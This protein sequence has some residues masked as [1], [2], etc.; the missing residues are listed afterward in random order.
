[1]NSPDLRTIAVDLTPIL[2]GGENGG[3]KV[4]V[5][6]LLRGLFV[7]APQTQFILLTQASS[8]EELAV[9]DAPNVQ[10]QMVVGAAV[11]NSLRPGL[12]GMASR[13]LPYLPGSLRNIFYRG[14]YK[15]HT[16]LKRGGSRKLMRDKGVDLLFC[17]FTG[18]TYAE[19]GI[20]TICTIYDL[21]YK[22]YPQFF[23]PADY[24]IRE[25]TF[26]DA[27]HKATALTAI[28]DYSR[29]SA[30]ANSN[31]DPDRISTIHL[32]MAQRVSSGHVQDDGVLQRLGLSRQRY[33]LYP[34]NFWKHKNHEMALTAFGMAC[35]QGLPA[36]FKLVCS[37]A[38][39]ARQAELIRD[40]QAMNLGAKV[41]WPGFLPQGE[42]MSL[43]ANCSGMIFPSLYEGFGL[44]VIEAMAAGVPVACSNTTALLE[45]AAEAALLFDPRVPAEI[46]QAMVSLANDEKLRNDL[47]RSGY[48]RSE[49]FMDSQR[50]VN[51]YWAVFKK[52]LYNS[53]K[54]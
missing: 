17:P 9:L 3:A 4:F 36:D 38:P 48:E 30:L 23:A 15:V 10:R 34:A 13:L 18:P 54:I 21:Q 32:R 6:E 19:P 49:E 7:F 41:V 1:M 52:F 20:P 22:T 50:M 33:L 45:V 35:R 26:L 47:I 42:L 29:N 27:C 14:G 11:T 43:L 51:E 25:Q 37:G 12:L 5:L 28:S 8:H 16:W 39:G 24:A 31:L 53:K 2:P 44:P 46:A 40:A